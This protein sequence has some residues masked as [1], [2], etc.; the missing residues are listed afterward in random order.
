MKKMRKM[1]KF[2]DFKFENKDVNKIDGE[3]SK[4]ELTELN[5]AAWKK[6]RRA[7][8][9]IVHNHGFFG[10]LLFGMRIKQATDPRIET[11]A[12][13]GLSIMYSPNFVMELTNNE[14]IFVLCH[15]VMHCVLLHFDR[16]HGK[17]PELFNIAGDYAINLLLNDGENSVGDMPKMGLYDT[18]YKNWDT[19]QIYEFLEKDFKD[20]KKKMQDLIDQMLDGMGKDVFKP[21]E[22]SGGIDIY[23]DGKEGKGEGE[24]SGEG[25]NELEKASKN[26]QGN[27]SK[28]QISQ[29]WG[30]MV[31]QAASKHQGSGAGNLDRFLRKITKPKVNWKAELKRFVAK[32]YGK[33]RH[34]IPNRRALGRGDIDWGLKKTPSDYTDVVIAIDTSGSIGSDDLDKFAS[35]MDGIFKE[36]SIQKCHIIWCDSQ[37][38]DVQEFDL[39]KNKFSIEKLKPCGGL[40]T[41]F[42]PP[43]DWVQENIVKKG[44]QPAFMVYFTDAFGESPNRRHYSTF[45][46]RVIW[47]VSNNDDPSNLTFGKKI[48]IDKL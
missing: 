27:I 2:D 1:R 13:D 12:T 15:E 39:R 25:Q 6:V 8:L 33:L 31:R 36:R 5:D 42:V 10:S 11:M 44:R 3:L 22:L 19:E 32:I 40:G 26:K 23:G 29:T 37:I 14:I 46:D 30:E 35:E 18:K 7:I 47:I 24:G 20:N 48:L 21:G 16:G 4:E 41:S 38:C 28:E 43:F 45:A 34:K 17:D 9:M